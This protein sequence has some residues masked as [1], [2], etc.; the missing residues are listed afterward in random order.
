[1]RRL[2]AL[3]VAATMALIACGDDSKSSSPATTAAAATT[4]TTATP[5]GPVDLVTH[6]SFNVSDPVK[7][8]ID[9]TVG[10]VT[11]HKNN[12]DAGELASQLILTAGKPLGDVAFGIDNTFAQKTLANNVFEPY[13]SPELEHLAPELR[14]LIPGHEL[15][16]I[17][18]GDVCVNADAKWFKAH[19]LAVPSTLDDLTDPRYKGL[20]VA[21]DPTT[22]SPGRAFLFATIARYGADG[23]QDYWKKLRTN[24]VTISSGW[25]DA[26]DGEYTA[27]SNGKGKHPLMVSYATSPP[28]EIVYASEPKPTEPASVVMTDSCYRQVEFAG[29]LRGAKHPEQARRLIDALLSQEFQTD[30]PLEMFVMPARS[31]IVLPDLFRFAA[32][33]AKPLQLDPVQVNANLD[34]WLDAWTKTAL[35]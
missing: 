12:G 16:P 11:I 25:Q 4:A 29:V 24:G 23:W 15:S 32:Q 17:D 27:S 9:R 28:A 1:M 7:A 8:D 18:V 19:N 21:M 35:R 6:D 22:S 33:P 5:V 10:P 3:S 26:Y 13:Q 20:L 31:G 14:N 34:R 2:I 30:V